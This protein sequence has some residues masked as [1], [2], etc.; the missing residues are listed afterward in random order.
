MPGLDRRGAR[1]PGGDKE[2]G[3]GPALGPAPPP[4][5][6]PTASPG[7]GAA[8]TSARGS[9]PRPHLRQAEQDAGRLDELAAHHAEVGLCVG[10]EATRHGRRET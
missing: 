7:A 9:R 10:V 4:T 5:K 8:V 1:G 3:P 6:D 2:R